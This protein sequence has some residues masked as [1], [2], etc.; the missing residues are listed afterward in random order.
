M[1]GPEAIGGTVVLFSA[2]LAGLSAMLTRSA[3]VAAA[4]PRPSHHGER[5]ARDQVQVAQGALGGL[6]RPLVMGP[7]RADG[8]QDAPP[9]VAASRTSSRAASVACALS[10]LATRWTP[11]RSGC[12]PRVPTRCAAAGGAGPGTA[13][14]RPDTWRSLA[15]RRS[16]QGIMDVVTK[17]Y[18]GEGIR[19]FYKVRFYACAAGGPA[20]PP[21]TTA[22][23]RSGRRMRRAWRRPWSVSPP[24][25]PSASWA[26]ASARTSS[27]ARRT[28]RCAAP[29]RIIVGRPAA[30]NPAAVCVLARLD[31]GPAH[32]PPAGYR[33]RYLWYFHHRDH[34]AR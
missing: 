32:H 21:L 18:R 34:G 17:T 5:H 10:P 31:G 6:P 8:D 19:G 7:C 14:L 11:S 27:G 2:L 25:M 20:R 3:L 12:R 28:R 16:L 9:P 15:C 22:V 26:T 13:G 29:R 30:P 33:R 1:N 4:C 24:C 23:A